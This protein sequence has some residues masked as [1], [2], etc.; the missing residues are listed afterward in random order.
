MRLRPSLPSR[1]L[2]RLYLALL[3]FGITVGFQNCGPAMHSTGQ[4]MSSSSS[5]SSDPTSPAPSPSGTPVQDSA[6]FACT[7]TQGR[8]ATNI[9]FRR[10]TRFEY[11]NTVRDIFGTD[12][13][14]LVANTLSGYAPD[15]FKTGV[16]EYSPSFISTDVDTLLSVASQIAEAVAANSTYLK[17][18]APSCLFNTSNAIVLTNDT[19]SQNF[20]SALGLKIYRRPLASAEI[21]NYLTTLKTSSTVVV[22]NSDKV[23]VVIGQMLSQPEMLFQFANARSLVG[24]RYQVDPYTVASRLSYRVIGSVPDDTLFAAAAANQLSTVAQLQAQAK[25]LM[26]KGTQL[27]YMD[28][29]GRR[30]VR[31]FYSTWLQMPIARNA[32]P[33]Y[34]TYFGVNSGTIKADLAEEAMRFGEYVTF[35]LNGQF[36]D[37]MSSDKSFAPTADA[38][39]VLGTTVSTGVKDPKTAGDARRGLFE[40]P[41]LMMSSS[42]RIANIHRGAQFLKQMMCVVL[43]NPPANADNVAASTQATLDLTNTTSRQIATA[44]TSSATCTACHSTINPVGFA[45]DSFGPLGEYQTA[46]KTFDSNNNYVRSLQIQ[47][48]TDLLL[49]GAMKSLA[50]PSD[51]SQIATAS[52]QI[53]A[54]FAQQIFRYTHYVVE[55]APDNCLLS[56]IESSVRSGASLV[57]VFV[58]NASTED[59]LWEKAN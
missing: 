10:L 54:C 57:D 4:A 20:I 12:V 2:Y 17:R 50:S 40:R 32:D 27:S 5:S 49:D 47:Y 59:L 11:E 9:P 6:K 44:E 53:K 1:P 34:S 52:T 55:S 30:F 8:G 22:T 46:E 37:L 19:C 39:K 56:D 51:L 24:D 36:S 29:P 31:N 35:D 33:F 48:G 18:V 21:A 41:I 28:D 38:A 26:T 14:A 13:D 43:G 23:A 25:R 16:T 7:D 45:F 58:K 42:S 15:V 3:A